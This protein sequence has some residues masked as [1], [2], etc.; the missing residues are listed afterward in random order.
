MR[1]FFG[2][3]LEFKEV[4]HLFG[5]EAGQLVPTVSPAEATI[6]EWAMPS[7][8]APLSPELIEFA[9]NRIPLSRKQSKVWRA[10]VSPTRTGSM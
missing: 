4:A 2:T 5:Q 6:A 10:I 9:L 7:A 3:A 1:V 8:S